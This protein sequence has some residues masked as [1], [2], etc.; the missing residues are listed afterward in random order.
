MKRGKSPVRCSVVQWFSGMLFCVAGSAIY[1]TKLFG[2]RNETGG[3]TQQ[4]GGG[5][6]RKVWFGYG[7]K[8]REGVTRLINLFYQ[9]N[10]RFYKFKIYF[11]NLKTI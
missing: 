4:V 7:N 10:F 3:R 11:N 2:F 6:I 8:R 9:S 5:G 1:N